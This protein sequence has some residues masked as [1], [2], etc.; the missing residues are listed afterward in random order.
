MGERL[1]MMA[2]ERRGFVDFLDGT[3]CGGGVEAV[4]EEGWASVASDRHSGER[5]TGEKDQLCS[6]APNRDVREEMAWR[7]NIL[8]NQQKYR[9]AEFCQSRFQ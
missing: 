1:R 8:T 5:L 7:P 4:A 6:N 9:R 3:G 2:V